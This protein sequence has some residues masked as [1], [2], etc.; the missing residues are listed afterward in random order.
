MVE[1]KAVTDLLPDHEAQLFNYMRVSR[2]AVGYLVNFS[3]KKATFNGNGS[4]S[5]TSTSRGSVVFSVAPAGRTG[6]N[7]PFIRG[8]RTYRGRSLVLSGTAVAI[9]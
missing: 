4:S 2:I 6:S 8:I 9:G 7:A 3:A 5:V 1:L